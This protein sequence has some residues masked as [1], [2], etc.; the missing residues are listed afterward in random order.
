MSRTID[1]R[2]QSFSRRSLLRASLS[3]VGALA[4][5]QALPAW[6]QSPDPDW[7]TT[8]HPDLR[9]DLARLIK[10]FGSFPKL[11]PETL[12]ASRDG[13]ARWTMPNR[14]DVPVE[15][16]MIKGPPGAPDVAIF[17]VNAM[18]EA[19]RPAILHTHGGGFVSG[20]AE[21]SVRPMQDLAAELG[22][23]IVTVDYRLAPET[24]WQGSL[25]DNYAALKWLHVNAATLG[26][27]P[28]RIA[29]LGES[30]GG[31]H[32]ALLALTAR[33]RGE[34]PLA[35]Q[36]LIYPMLDDRTGSSRSVP[37]HIAPFG[38]SASDNRFGWQSFLGMAPGG[39][40]VPAAAVP[41]RAVSLS[42]LPPAF[43]GVGSLDLFVDEDIEYARRLNAAGVAAELIVVPGATHGFDMMVPNAPVVQ[44]FTAA[45]I[46]AL[47]RGLGLPHADKTR[48]E[49]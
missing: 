15:K 31:G 14:P 41:G 7:L 45:K 19:S 34:V 30:A 11:G 27:N 23:A 4:A 40:G 2:Q 47:R 33:D 35:F 22:C 25:E 39:R 49:T 17:L 18:R 32:A 42:G 38:W 3:G 44:R 13:M 28:A 6:A 16:R 12:A 5:A 43:I 10:Q 26:I 24:R 37:K 1:L 29:L 46:D 48:K 21:L 8:I 20:T 36:C 9:D